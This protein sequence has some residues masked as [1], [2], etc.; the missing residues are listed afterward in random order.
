MEKVLSRFVVVDEGVCDIW[1]NNMFPI[2]IYNQR[3]EACPRVRALE[4]SPEV[5][6]VY[7]VY[8]VSPM[9]KPRRTLQRMYHTWLRMY[10]AAYRCLGE[11][12]ARAF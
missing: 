5:A 10:P 11:E 6:Y 8:D 2:Q 7:N 12:Y 3:T 1:H 9:N 4:K